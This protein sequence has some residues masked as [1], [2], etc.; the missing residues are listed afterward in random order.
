MSDPLKVS[1]AGADSRRNVEQ[2]FREEFL[3]CSLCSEA[4][5]QDHRVA[6]YLPCLHTFCREC[7]LRYIGNNQQQCTC[8]VCRKESDIPKNGV[9]GI[10]NNFTVENLKG[11]QDIFRAHSDQQGHGL[12]CTSCE[13]GLD[14]EHFCHDC[15]YFLCH[16]CTDAHRK[17]RQ[18]KGHVLSAIDDLRQKMYAPSWLRREK[19]N[20]HKGQDLTL[21][22]VKCEIPVCNTCA[23]AGH[24]KAEG[25]LLVELDGEIENAKCEL[26]ARA[27]EVGQL[28]EGMTQYAGQI[29]T[30]IN[31]LNTE[32]TQMETMITESFQLLKLSLDERREAALSDLRQLCQQKAKQFREEKDG[33]ESIVTQIESACAFADR[34]CNSANPSQLLGARNQVLHRLEELSLLASTPVT[35]S[36]GFRLALHASHYKSVADITQ[37]Y[38][39]LGTITP[40][41][42]VKQ[43]LKCQVRVQEPII[44]GKRCHAT[45]TVT[46]GHDN[47][48]LAL[49]A[50][51]VSLKATHAQQ[52][53]TAVSVPGMSSRFYT[54]GP[55]SHDAETSA[56]STW[57]APVGV[58]QRPTPLS[59]NIEPSNLKYLRENSCEINQEESTMY[60]ITF[61][62]EEPGS[63]ALSIKVNDEDVDGGHVEFEVHDLKPNAHANVTWK[64]AFPEVPHVI[65]VDTAVS[66][67]HDRLTEDIVVSARVVT[68]DGQE[69]PNRIRKLQGRFT[70]KYTPVSAGKVSVSIF[71]NNRGVVGNPFTVNVQNLSPGYTSVTWDP[72]P[73]INQI[74]RIYIATENENGEHLETGGRNIIVKVT[75]QSTTKDLPCAIVDNGDGT[76]TTSLIP[77]KEVVHLIRI[78]L[79]NMLLGRGVYEV[80][81]CSSKTVAKPEFVKSVSLAVS[82]KGEVCV[83][84]AD[85]QSIVSPD[86]K[87][88]QVELRRKL[89]AVS[90]PSSKIAFDS[91]GRLL[92]MTPRTR[93][94]YTKLTSG[95]DMWTIPDQVVQ[96]STFTLTRAAEIII[97]DCKSNA[98]FVF[99]MSGRLMRT[100]T[101][102]PG[103]MTEGVDNVCV[104]STNNILVSHGEEN[105]I[106]R[107]D[108]EGNSERILQMVGK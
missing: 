59:S 3:T 104:D 108:S 92:M 28:E 62:P 97:G 49:C 75:D 81:V 76:Y 34:A 63:H 94:V 102:S 80:Y 9:D 35:E 40:V 83:I 61:I 16:A 7:L 96:P 24:E 93:R 29:D 91:K 79:D 47:E 14:A 70:V 68:S 48:S 2:E 107:I 84:D 103:C 21:Y 65:T 18:L 39:K 51:I 89:D 58:D 101:L 52:Q 27:N 31:S 53:D 46:E 67:G 95:T 22:C 26:K 54:D 86:A 74:L 23:I 10:P 56:Q 36:P 5:D 4:Y 77:R 17:M 90:I 64:T 19:C 8:P 99:S 25:H 12:Q 1:E 60:K 78:I 6:K 55:R 41:L 42:S 13:D 73:V 11:Y 38:S 50:E 66:Q 82:R 106:F 57:Y 45:V 71:V 32:C 105:S 88:Q 15:G 98:L 30:A 20:Q 33:V 85:S 100:A 69:I 72:C 43:A 44:V 87:W 37:S